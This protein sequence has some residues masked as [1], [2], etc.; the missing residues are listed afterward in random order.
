MTDTYI[1]TKRTHTK[2]DGQTNS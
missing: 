2:T 1:Y